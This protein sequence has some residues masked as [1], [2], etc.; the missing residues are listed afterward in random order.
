MSPTPALAREPSTVPAEAPRFRS[1]VLPPTGPHRVSGDN[2]KVA[3]LRPAKER[4]FQPRGPV[5]T[6]EAHY[7]GILPVYGIIKGGLGAGSVLAIK[8]HSRPNAE[9]EP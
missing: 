4:S 7:R 8:Q 3:P 6:G 5:I 9:V 2:A 1:T